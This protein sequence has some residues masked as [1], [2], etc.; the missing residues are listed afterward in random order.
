MESLF[1]LYKA[2]LQP[3][4][5]YVLPGWFP[6][7]RFTNLTKLERVHRAASRAISGCLSSST[8]FLLLSE[9]SLSPLR[10]SLTHFSLTSCSL[11][12]KLLSI[13]SLARLGVKPSLFRFSWRAF[14][15]LTGSCFL[16]LF[17]RRFT[18]L[19]SSFP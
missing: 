2:F 6:F 10:V 5:I 4:F 7:F 11:S 17:L 14:H 16:L 15:S 13:S 9:T 18:L 1:L 19:A 3:L 12:P 8:I